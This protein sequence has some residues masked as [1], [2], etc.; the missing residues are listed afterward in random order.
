MKCYLSTIFFL[1]FVFVIIAIGDVCV[2]NP[3][4]NDG[5]CQHGVDGKLFSCECQHGFLGARCEC[6][7]MM[8]IIFLVSYFTSVIPY[9][10]NKLKTANNSYYSLKSLLI[11][12]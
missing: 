3:C 10:Y 8:T 9:S 2:P 7:S 1:S 5:V 12:N 4:D 11:L 6:K